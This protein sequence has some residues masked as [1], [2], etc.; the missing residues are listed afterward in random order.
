MAG[1]NP[2]S[3]KHLSTRHRIQRRKQTIRSRRASVDKNINLHT[4]KLSIL[5]HLSWMYD[6]TLA[7]QCVRARGF[8]LSV[9]TSKHNAHN[10]HTSLCSILVVLPLWSHAAAELGVERTD[11]ITKLKRNSRRWSN[12]LWHHLNLKWMLPLAHLLSKK[13]KKKKN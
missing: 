5:C 11:Y 6:I 9:Q 1:P 8:L 2:N 3:A 12:V 4:Y 13:K 7:A 10:A